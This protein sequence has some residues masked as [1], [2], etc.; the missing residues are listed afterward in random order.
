[1]RRTCSMPI[2]LSSAASVSAAWR[3]SALC[4]GRVEIEGIRRRAFNS[5]RKRERFSRAKTIAGE[6][7]QYTLEWEC[8]K[9]RVYAL[10]SIL[11]L[12][13]RVEFKALRQKLKRQEDQDGERHAKASLSALARNHRQPVGCLGAAPARE[14]VL[15]PPQQLWGFRGV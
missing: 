6:D 9:V 14:A 15:Q 7:M 1:M 5:S 10:A 12:R 3:T 11:V 8:V 13:E 4:S 2:R